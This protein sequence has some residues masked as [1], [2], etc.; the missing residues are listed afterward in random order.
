MESMH[1]QY[2]RLKDE[3]ESAEEAL[4]EAKKPFLDELTM[5]ED[6]MKEATKDLA[7]IIETRESQIRNLNVEIL[8]TSDNNGPATIELQDGTKVI[9]SGI[10]SVEILNRKELLGTLL[11]LIPED[12][13]L[14]FTV[15]FTDK[16]LIPLLDA[17]IIPKE[18]AAI[19]TTFRLSVKRKP[20]D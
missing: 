19:N 4:K 8:N 20:K 10:K 2:V 7:A 16:G 13:K 14:P 9:R 3:K 17:N 15:K 6:Q 12:D 11:N 18:L 5:I 1:E